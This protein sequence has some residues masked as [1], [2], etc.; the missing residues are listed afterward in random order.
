MKKWLKRVRGALGMGVTW[1]IAWGVI[2]GAIMEGIVDREG[3]IVD[4]WPQ[5][6]AMPGFLL[7]V[8]FSVML[9]MSEGRRRFDELSVARFAGLGAAA[10]AVLGTLF[11]AAGIFPG[12]PL[13]VRAAVVL[14]PLTVLSAAS[15]TGT[16]ALARLAVDRGLLD[17]GDSRDVDLPGG[18]VQDRLPGRG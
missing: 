10:G 6:L 8:A 13:L 9:W 1:A 3:R 16:L 11:L 4:M 7:G 14:G 5:L 12:I 2:G 18:Q 15:A 17:A